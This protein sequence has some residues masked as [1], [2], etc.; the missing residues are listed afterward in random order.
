MAWFYRDKHGDV[1]LLPGQLSKDRN[2]MIFPLAFVDLLGDGQEES[3]WLLGGYNRGGY[4]LFYD[5][6]RHRIDFSWGYH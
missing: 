3:L 5:G 1:R 4:A 2:E 6:F